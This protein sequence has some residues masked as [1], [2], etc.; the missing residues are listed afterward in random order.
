MKTRVSA[1]FAIGMIGL[2]GNLAFAQS[3]DYVL[4]NVQFPDRCYSSVGS[5]TVLI[6][7][8]DMNQDA[9]QNESVPIQ[10]WSSRD[11]DIRTPN[12]TETGQ[13]TGIFEVTV[14]FNMYDEAFS[15]RIRVFE[16]DTLYAK[17]IDNNVP[18]GLR[19]D[20]EA[21]VVMG[22]LPP[23]Q[24]WGKYWESLSI[25]NDSKYVC[26]TCMAE[27]IAEVK[28]T[29]YAL[30]ALDVIY[31][32][33][34][35]QIGSG[36]HVDE[37]LC[38][39]NLVLILK[40]D[41][42][43]ACIKPETSAK[44]VDRGWTAPVNEWPSFTTIIPELGK[45]GTYELEKDGIKFDIK[46]Y[47]KGGSDIKEI[48]PDSKYNAVSII[49]DPHDSGSLEITIPRELIDSKMSEN[50]DEL[51]FVL[52]DKKEV[53]YTETVDDL[54][55]TLTIKFGKESQEIEIIGATPI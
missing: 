2:V 13:D 53:P 24:K 20:I 18:F 31:H 3:S 28:P 9:E 6:I 48:I 33:P 43:P 1:I 5:G 10:L 26:D 42:A 37:V 17:Y 44:L 55:R 11:T 27:F 12:A 41:G 22:T 39:D 21:E 8:P 4:G 38:K 16:G 30:N 50:V 54:T 35:R 14:F 36:L 7:D 49:L 40:H 46:Y 51:F 19:Q 47:I 23:D 32:A 34:L 25:Q 52:I 29:Q 45:T 15:Q